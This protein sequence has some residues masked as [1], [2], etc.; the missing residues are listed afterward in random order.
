MRAD[1][2][3]EAMDNNYIIHSWAEPSS[4]RQKS[5]AASVDLLP[6]LHRL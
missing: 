3:Q 6:R 5:E 2:M 4:G 1:V